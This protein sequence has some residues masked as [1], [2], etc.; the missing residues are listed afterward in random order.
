M[1]LGIQDALPD[2]SQVPLEIEGPLVQGARGY[3]DNS[4]HFGG[5]AG[6]KSYEGRGS[7][8]YTRSKAGL[9]DQHGP[10]TDR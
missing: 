2:P 6:A 10:R 1:A 9:P 3:S 5:V 8:P 4:S 7:C